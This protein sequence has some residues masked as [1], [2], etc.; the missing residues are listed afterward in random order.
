MRHTSANRTWT[1][2]LPSSVNGNEKSSISAKSEGWF[3]ISSETSSAMISSGDDGG[4]G[5]VRFAGVAA[6]AWG[7][8]TSEWVEAETFLAGFF[9][10]LVSGCVI[11][12]GILADGQVRLLW[13][14]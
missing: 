6:A 14:G 12:E 5:G 10:E 2:S 7:S 1:S 9:S 8:S 3:S 11:G 13:T 4:G